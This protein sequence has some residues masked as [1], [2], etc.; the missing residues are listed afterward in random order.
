MPG[1]IYPNEKAK[2]LKMLSKDE[3][4]IIKKDYPFKKE[5]NAKIYELIQRG[6]SP[7]IL[8][9]LTGGLRKSSVHRIGQTGANV[10]YSSNKEKVY[11]NDLIKIQTAFAAF[12][13]EIKKI[14]HGRK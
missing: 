7:I 2:L 14:L 12:N 10:S 13:K 8:T 11:N 9:E 6:V 4:K 1:K 5:R 3:I